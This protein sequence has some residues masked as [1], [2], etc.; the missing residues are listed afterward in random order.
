[1]VGGQCVNTGSS[2]LA[3]TPGNNLI[4][5]LGS[6]SNQTGTAFD[7]AATLAHEFGHNLGLTHCGANDPGG[8]TTP[9]CQNVGAFMPNLGSIMSYFY[10]LSG[11]RSNLLCQGLS[12]DEAALFKEIDYSHGTM[13]TLNESALD[14]VFGTGMISV[15]WDCSGVISGTVAQ[16]LN[17]NSN[18]WCGS[19]SGLQNLSDLDEWGYIEAHQAAIASGATTS[20]PPTPC[21]TANEV[22]QYVTAGACTQP[23]LSTEACEGRDMIYMHPAGG[24]GASGKCSFPYQN[25]QSAHN[26]A[27]DGSVM[28]FRAGSYPQPG[29]VLLTKPMK[30]FNQPTAG[31]STT[32]I[33]AP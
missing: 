6:F 24:G 8:G 13:C 22:Q 27:T 23:T 11:V 30:L 29:P 32:V 33:T 14:E 4:V 26:A 21:I 15:D 31:A 25:L 3:D 18:G 2:G 7:R 20:S 28:F 9:S 19:N 5:T 16:D 17:G 12:F 1:M 10:Q